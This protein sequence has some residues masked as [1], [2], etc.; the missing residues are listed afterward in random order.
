MGERVESA[1][2]ACGPARVA[3][4]ES[5]QAGLSRRGHCQPHHRQSHHGLLG[6][7]PAFPG[8]VQ[9]AR[10]RAITATITACT[11]ISCRPR[12][13]PAERGIFS[14]RRR[15]FRGTPAWA[16]G[17][18]QTALNAVVGDHDA[19]RRAKPHQIILGRAIGLPISRLWLCLTE[20]ERKQ[21]FLKKKNQKTFTT[22]GRT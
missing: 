14:R 10:S 4:L 21:F 2:S 11:A 12:E 22:L 7:R 1:A 9:G 17:A 6:E 8:R 3:R 18:I 16:E 5:T 19:S 13:P 15:A 20:E